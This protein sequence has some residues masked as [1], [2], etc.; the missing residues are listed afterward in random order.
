M[1]SSV[2]APK[3]GEC[4]QYSHYLPREDKCNYD[5]NVLPDARI[6]CGATSCD[7]QQC[8]HPARPEIDQIGWKVCGRLDDQGG[9]CDPPA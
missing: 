5:D 3:E 4:A 6:G 8:R 7:G 2:P 1:L 9:D